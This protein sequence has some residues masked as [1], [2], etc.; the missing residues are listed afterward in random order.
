M[1]L[2][3]EAVELAAGFCSEMG[4]AEELLVHLMSFRPRL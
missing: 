2:L 3:Y 4:L 1:F